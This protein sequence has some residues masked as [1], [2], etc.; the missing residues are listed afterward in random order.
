ME[1]D[2]RIEVS[3]DEEKCVKTQIAEAKKISAGK[4]FISGTFRKDSIRCGQRELAEV[5]D[6]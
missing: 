1:T 3:R 4:C 5:K 6:N 2:Y